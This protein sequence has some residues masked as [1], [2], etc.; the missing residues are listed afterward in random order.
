MAQNQERKGRSPI[1]SRKTSFIETILKSDWQ[2]ELAK[3]I[4]DT[5]L[6]G[7]HAGTTV[8]K[9][10]PAAAVDPPRMGMPVLCSKEIRN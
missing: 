5:I 6:D 8:L 7:N 9:I 10:N 2:A 1:L 3:R 4:D